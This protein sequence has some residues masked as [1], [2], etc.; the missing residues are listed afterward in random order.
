MCCTRRAAQRSA[1][2]KVHRYSPAV[3]T[4]SGTPPCPTWLQAGVAPPQIAE[5]AGHSV[6]RAPRVYA[7]C[8]TGT[9]D[10]AKRRILEATKAENSSSASEPD[11]SQ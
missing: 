8:S 3:P 10:E 2:R 9:Q 1:E 7:K 11:G 6:G 5:W 4:T